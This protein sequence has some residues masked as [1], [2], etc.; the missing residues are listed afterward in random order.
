MTKRHQQ[1]YQARKGIFSFDQLRI[2]QSFL[3]G[4]GNETIQPIQCLYFYISI[5]YSPMFS[6]ISF[7][8]LPPLRPFSADDFAFFADFTR[9]IVAAAVDALILFH[10]PRLRS[11]KISEAQEWS[12]FLT[13]EATCSSLVISSHTFLILLPPLSPPKTIP[14]CA[15]R[16]TAQCVPNPPLVC[17]FCWACR[18]LIYPIIYGLKLIICFVD[19]NLRIMKI[20][21]DCLSHFLILLDVLL[22][23]IYILSLGLSRIIFNYFHLFYNNKQYQGVT[24]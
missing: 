9:P 23:L 17:F 15:P 10:N 20:I 11:F 2:G 21:A 5:I 13:R 24:C 19:L 6:L 3:S 12:K 1:F 14:T 8:G 18:T 22:S 16:Y 7:F 4:R